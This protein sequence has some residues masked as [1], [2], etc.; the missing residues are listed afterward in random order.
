MSRG[1]TFHV[2]PPSMTRAY[3][4]R[5]AKDEAEAIEA[6]VEAEPQRY[7]SEAEAALYVTELTD[8]QVG[9]LNPAPFGPTLIEL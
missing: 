4:V 1:K 3:V 2:A 5:G 9:D 8:E 6:A 7:T